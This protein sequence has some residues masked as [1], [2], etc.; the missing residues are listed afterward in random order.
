M[1]DTHDYNQSTPPQPAE[2]KW[3]RA[4]VFMRIL[5]LRGAWALA[6]LLFTSILVFSAT[7]LMPGNVAELM[8]G[9]FASDEAISALEVKLGLDRP[10]IVQFGDWL[11]G[12]LT[13]DFGVSPRMSAPIGPLLWQ[14]LQMSLLL[15]GSSLVLVFLIGVTL[16]TLAALNRGNLLDRSI[17]S[18]SLLGISVPEFVSGCFLILVF[19]G[20]LP[21]S[22]YAPTDAG[23]WEWLSH[24]ILPVASL[25]FLM[26]AH[27]VRTA[28][29]SMVEALSEPYVRT[30][31]LKG[32][33]RRIVVLKHALRNAL[34]PTVTVLGINV[35]YLIGGVVVIEIVFSYPGLGRLT[36]FAV[37]N[38]DIPLI[39]ACTL[40]MAAI[41]IT[42]SFLTDAIYLYLNPRLRTG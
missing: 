19:T 20:I 5:G 3:R 42:A 28:R 36:V 35:G 30:A 11:G 23:L 4:R 7:Q 40:T 14:H 32:L 33:P 29:V 38:R 31:V 16:G 9:Q 21:I 15:A 24:L 25:T 13:G 22:G 18:I 26:L 39:Q 34:L 6:T 37:Q 17:A 2:V 8:L 10:A 1:G 41:Y 12:L 27:V